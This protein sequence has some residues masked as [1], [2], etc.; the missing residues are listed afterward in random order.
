MFRR[1]LA[2]LDLKVAQRYGHAEN[3]DSE[4]AARGRDCRPR[5][6]MLVDEAA[7]EGAVLASNRLRGLQ[8]TQPP[9]SF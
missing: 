5:D 7:A 1:I 3:A 8:K 9:S 2:S 6:W 4:G